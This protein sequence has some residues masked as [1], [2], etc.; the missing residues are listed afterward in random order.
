MY[1]WRGK[2]L[3][4]DLTDKK[5]QEENLEARVARDYIGGRG[6]GAYYLNREGDPGCDPL[7]PENMMVMA[8]GPLTGTSAPTASR[9][10][11]MTKGPLT[12]AITCSNS[13]GQFPKELKWAGYDALIFTGRAAEPVYL[14]IDQG[15]AEL[16]P[17]GHLWGKWV[18]ETTDTLLKETD[19]K[20]RVA[21]I[22]PAGE[23]LVL[24]AS[25]MNEK[26]RAAGR[27][28]VG[29]VMGSKNLKA[30]VVRG[31]DPV[32]MANKDRFAEIQN[33]V[34]NKFRE[35]VKKVGLLP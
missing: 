2:I 21:C 26:D 7:S 12:N 28:G 11:V 4:V 24:F 15:K 22:G 30:V 14:W 20:G 17:A 35:G 34:L 33:E 3:R 29:A 1:G 10:M 16:R 32:P 25:I 13:G 18:P 31:K 27:S 19:P 5:I 6:L 23:K 8:T 9:Y